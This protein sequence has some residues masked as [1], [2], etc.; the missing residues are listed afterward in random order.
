MLVCTTKRLQALE[1]EVGSLQGKLQAIQAEADQKQVVVVHLSEVRHETRGMLCTLCT[2]VV[3]PFT[4]LMVI[5]VAAL[6]AEWQCDTSMSL[7]ACTFCEK[8]APDQEYTVY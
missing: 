3:I 1:T 6:H 2:Q 4:Q 5:V 8:Y 7:M